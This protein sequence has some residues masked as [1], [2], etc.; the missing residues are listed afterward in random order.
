VLET[1]RT[2]KLIE[3][4]S[5]RIEQSIKL[6]KKNFIWRKHALAISR[7]IFHHHSVDV[8]CLVDYLM[9]GERKL[10][11]HKINKAT[12]EHKTL[13][14]K[15]LFGTLLNR[16]NEGLISESLVSK[17]LDDRW[18]D[19]FFKRIAASEKRYLK[20][21]GRD[22]PGYVLISPGKHCNLACE[23]T[24][25]SAEGCIA[26]GRSSGYLYIN[27]NGDVVPCI[28]MEEH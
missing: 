20:K 19:D 14:M 25:P 24:S 4:I 11:P 12:I 22:P 15:A 21:Y 16:V 2:N 28:V 3:T 5:N 26:A 1:A 9:S 13:L 6:S 18:G 17:I 7:K 23:G 8:D 10:S 27:W